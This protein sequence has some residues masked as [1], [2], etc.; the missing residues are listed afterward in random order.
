MFEVEQKLR[1]N[2][3]DDYNQVLHLYPRIDS[4]FTK[5]FESD[6]KFINERAI[7]IPGKHKN[8]KWVD[9]AYILMGKVKM[10]RVKLDS[11][12]KFFRYI[13]NTFKD[14]KATQE[15]QL[16]LIQ[17]FMLQNEPRYARMAEDLVI[18]KEPIHRNELLY[19]KTLADY[20]RMIEDYTKMLPHVEAAVQYEK[21]KDERARLYYILGQLYRRAG[22]EEEAFAGSLYTTSTSYEASKFQ[23]TKNYPA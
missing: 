13:N 17:T 5:S 16:Y 10:Y 4:N 20:Y 11:A 21:L 1:D 9:D 8:S 7:L 15:A 6:F 2:H 3:V 14:E 23:G 18:K 19:H 12:E 22:Q